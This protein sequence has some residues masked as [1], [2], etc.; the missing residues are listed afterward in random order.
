MR[1]YMICEHNNRV[2][3]IHK[4]FESAFVC[5]TMLVIK[6][7]YNTVLTLISISTDDYG[8]VISEAILQTTVKL[9]LDSTEL[10]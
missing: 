1:Y 3:A 7:N 5:Y 4:T 10:L 9:P 2:I 6:G 8:I